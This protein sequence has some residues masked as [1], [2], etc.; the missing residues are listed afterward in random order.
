MWKV[1]AVNGMKLQ[2]LT[3]QG[4]GKA[5]NVLARS[6]FIALSEMAYIIFCFLVDKFNL[7]AIVCFFFQKKLSNIVQRSSR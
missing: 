3:S 4:I 1:A 7:K 5:P 6:L 2:G